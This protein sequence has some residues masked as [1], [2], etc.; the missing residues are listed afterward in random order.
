MSADATLMIWSGTTG[1]NLLTC[2]GHTGEITGV[3]W[4]P[5]GTKIATSSK[6]KSSILWSAATGEKLFT[7]Q[8][9]AKINGVMWSPDGTKVLTIS[10]GFENGAVVWS[11]A[12]GERL[13]VIDYA[14]EVVAADWSPDGTK[15]ALASTNKPILIWSTA[16]ENELFS[17]TDI[18]FIPQSVKWSPDGKS[19]AAVSSSNGTVDVCSGIT[20]SKLCTLIDKGWSIDWSSDGTKILTSVSICSAETGKSLTFLGGHVGQIDNLRWSAD[21][22]KVTTISSADRMC[23]LWSATSGA[24]TSTL[25]CSILTG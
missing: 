7:L 4:S 22:T 9:T 10:S 24:K 14:F 25:R 20:G 2:K 3:M 23:L 5:D 12:T 8:Q 17:L 19:I 11:A 18:T 15:I 16:T 13:R 6:D 21:G 1:A